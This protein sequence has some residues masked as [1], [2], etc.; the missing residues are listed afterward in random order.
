VNGTFEDEDGEYMSGYTQADVEERALR[1]ADRREKDAELLVRGAERMLDRVQTTTGSVRKIRNG[2]A[3][4]GP[5]T[6]L[7]IAVVVDGSVEVWPV[8]AYGRSLSM[9]P[10][11][12]GG[13]IGLGADIEVGS[14]VEFCWSWNSIR[15]PRFRLLEAVT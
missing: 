6:R 14:L 12:I 11:P 7:D 10:D 4:S 15:N 13:P 2:T 9:K 5:Y 3:Q 8:Y 1:I